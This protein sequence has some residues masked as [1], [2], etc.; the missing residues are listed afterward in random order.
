MSDNSVSIELNGVTIE[1]LDSLKREMLRLVSE[2]PDKQELEC[3]FVVRPQ[4]LPDVCFKTAPD[5]K[6]H[7]ELGDV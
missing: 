1:D 4:T 5:Y 7:F 3:E 2:N 6:F